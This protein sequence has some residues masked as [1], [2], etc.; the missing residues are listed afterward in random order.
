MAQSIRAGREL[1]SRDGRCGNEVRTQAR[2]PASTRGSRLF[3]RCLRF[4]ALM[5]DSRTPTPSRSSLAVA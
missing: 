3:L 5:V 2:A 1:L 4:P